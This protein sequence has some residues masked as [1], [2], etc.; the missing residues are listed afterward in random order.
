MLKSKFIPFMLPLLLLF[1]NGSE[2]S[3]AGSRQRSSG[4]QTGIL[5]KMIVA[6]GNVAMD[7]RSQSPQWI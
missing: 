5:E 2:N 3:I 4:A 6:N 1:S 7:R